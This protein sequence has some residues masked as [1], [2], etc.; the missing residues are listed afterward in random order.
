[1]PSV[2]VIIVSY[3][4]RYYIEQCVDSV[5][6]SLPDAQ[7]IVIDN[8]SADGS[9]E[10]LRSRFPQI[11]VIA[12]PENSGFGSANNIALQHAEGRYVLFLNPDTVVAE[13]TLPGCVNFMDENPGVGALGVRMQYGNGRFA[14]ESRR[15]VPTP[16]VSFY[17][18]SGLGRLFPHSRR[19][20]RY[21]MTYMDRNSDCPIEVVSG[22][23]M[24]ART[25]VV[26]DLGGFDESFFMY[27]EDID[28]SYRILKAGYANHYLPLPI[29]HFKGESTV[30]TSFRYAKVFYDAMQ[31]FYDKHFSSYRKVFSLFV[32]LL[33]KIKQ[34]ST[35]I[36]QNI[37]AKRQKMTVGKEPCLFVGSKANYDKVQK[38]VESSAFL[39]D[40]S[41]IECASDISI[42]DYCLT[43][44]GAVLFDVDVFGYGKVMEWMYNTAGAG[45]TFTMGL[46]N[47]ATG[48]L[49]TEDEVL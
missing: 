45:Q 15:S 21:H 10:Y 23:F 38:L 40:A 33:L 47:S 4:V 9:V 49:V 36:G 24:F 32:K 48:H 27:G 6:R 5:L 42:P 8:A 25:D 19:F 20:G 43:G 18:M 13:K 29:V 3:K 7:I 14:L 35:Y 22:A 17:H 1:M 26:R 34:I 37:D 30:K 11:E 41:F 28:L 31:I 2:S 39:R 12:N 46:F 44:Q 16:G